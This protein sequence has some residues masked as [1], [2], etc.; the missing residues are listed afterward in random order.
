MNMQK[1]LVA[2]LLL[3]GCRFCSAKDTCFDCHLVMEGMSTKFTNDIH[4]SK[5]VSCATCHGG[6]AGETNMNLSMSAERGFKVRVQR[7]GIPAFCG[8]CHSDTNFMA[9][10]DPELKTDQLAK[11]TN[12][13][14]GKLLA[15]GRRRAAE[16]VDCHGVHEIRPPNDPKSMVSPQLVSKT[17]SKCHATTLEAYAPSRHAQLFV[18]QR[19]PGCIV[20]HA[21]HDTAEPTTAMLTGPN[22]VCVDCHRAGSPPAKVGDDIAK[23]LKD[24]EAAGPDKKDALARARVAVHSMSLAIVKKAAETPP[25]ANK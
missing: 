3:L 25:P 17:C 1:L 6:D 2:I 13:V 23:Y 10:V 7:Q 15:S 12:G 18:N 11:Y 16:C 8:Q 19:R 5:S 22:S 20:C 21:S 4:F 14:H 24:L 9:K